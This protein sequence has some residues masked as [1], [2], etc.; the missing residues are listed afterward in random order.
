[1]AR[2]ILFALLLTTCGRPVWAAA[3]PI[4]ETLEQKQYRLSLTAAPDG[5]DES[6]ARAS[7][8]TARM[9][10]TV[11]EQPS[12][13]QREAVA[14]ATQP[15]TLN[16]GAQAQTLGTELE[17]FGY[18]IFSSPSDRY[19]SLED[20]PVPDD[21][22]VG[23]GDTLT[24]QVWGKKNVEYRLTITRE[25]HLLIPE[26]GPVDITG[27]RF[28]EVRETLV[29]RF[30]AEL[31]GAKATVT[32]NN[33]KTVQIRVAGDVVKPGIYTVSGFTTLINAILTTGGPTRMGSLRGIELK[34]QG[35]TIAT[36]DLYDLL[37]SGDT[38]SDMRIRHNDVLFFPPVDRLVSLAGEVQRP[39][40]YELRSEETLKD[41]VTLGGGMLPT[42]SIERSHI[43]RI[44]NGQYRTLLDLGARPSP[45]E[46]DIVSGDFV[47]ILPLFDRMDRIVMMGGHLRKPGGYQWQEGLRLSDIVRIDD[48]LPG[49]DLEFAV[50]ASESA[51]DKRLTIHYFA[52][53]LALEES[54][55]ANAVHLKPRD[56]VFFLNRADNREGALSALTDQLR[57]EA[58]VLAPARI[59]QIVGPGIH[60]GTL[61]LPL[62]A[63]VEDV[64][65]ASGG[66]SRTLDP[67]YIVIART[68]A[69]T[70]MVEAQSVTYSE[71]AAVPMQPGD[72]LYVFDPQTRRSDLLAEELA[73]MARQASY[74]D[75]PR[76]VSIYGNVVS[77]GRFPL[78]DGMRTSDLICASG[79]LLS[80][81]HNSEIELS[82]F[83]RENRPLEHHVL[84]A[85]AILERCDQKYGTQPARQTGDEDPLLFPGDQLTVVDQPGW[86]EESV[87]TL[88]GEIY[89]PGA[90]VIG[91]GETLCQVM[92]R[93]GGLTHDA[94]AFGAVFT[95]Q[96]VREMQQETLQRIQDQ[97]DDLLVDLSL[98]H[99]ANNSEKTP[100]GDQK[101]DYLRAIRQLEK[102]QASG[103]MVIDLE[104]ASQCD[105]Q[106]DIVLENGDRL[107]VP[108][109]GHYVYVVGQVYVPTSHMFREDRAVADYL[110][111]SGG[112]TVL[113]R[114]SDTFVVQANGEV[115]G[116]RGRRSSK[117]ILR[118]EV[119]PGA[120][121]HVPLNVDR[122]NT[123]ERIQS[124]TRSLF[125]A[126]VFAGIAL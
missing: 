99:S 71:S 106:A 111:L 93:A 13:A 77:P 122:M 38:S 21:Y 40:I 78:E 31:I 124:W 119:Q 7:E 48:L 112:H 53:G 30:A 59:V 11:A 97:L 15:I 88:E 32:V 8:R 80:R 70:G 104:A 56:Q 92:Q 67:A 54:N 12:A 47:R 61:P 18:G 16:Q 23:P 36:V 9:L 87:V 25:G 126:A 116:L 20:V 3:D 109:R 14:T 57:K 41:V 22:R 35:E 66:F 10:P 81:G 17:H 117:R 34:R 44:V 26:L 55:S 120:T 28:D 82:R 94:Y 108:R 62:E 33:P 84:D 2:V 45:M 76:I 102:A 52:P 68:D 95:R 101:D 49:A 86:S 43:E 90:Y 118:T 58:T 72:R 103:R 105:D 113:G 121:I 85:G 123:T 114:L 98:S 100:A 96:S 4:L 125:E 46:T 19:E 115:M 1:M 6:E 107:N 64:L 42:A 65:V 63:T 73:A 69:E 91:R 79:G 50:L 60:T 27:L 37:I 74:R 24:V 110:K 5:F 89:R 29:E 51:E 39:G 75:R 83:G